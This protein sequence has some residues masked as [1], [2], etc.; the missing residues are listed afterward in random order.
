MKISTQVPKS[1]L[2]SRWLALCTPQIGGLEREEW[3]NTHVK[4]WKFFKKKDEAKTEGLTKTEAKINITT[5]VLA[6]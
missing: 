3:K 6:N 5:L 4:V 2:K 1:I